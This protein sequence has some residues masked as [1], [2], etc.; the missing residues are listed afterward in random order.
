M[1]EPRHRAVRHGLRLLTILILLPL[2]AAAASAVAHAAT[3][4]AAVSTGP[5]LAYSFDETGGAAVTDSSGNGN[6]GTAANT[7][8]STAGKY[9]GTLSLNGTSSWGTVPDSP[10][11]DLTTGMT[12]E[13]WVNPSAIAGDWRTVVFKEQA[14]G[15]VYSLY[16]GESTGRALGQ[17]N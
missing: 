11:P 17:V 14:G 5:V 3:T 8:W 15:M 13:A 2:A 7:S 16:A 6:N 10:S 12:L 1:A 4:A 9:G